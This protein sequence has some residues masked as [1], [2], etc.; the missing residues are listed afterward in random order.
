MGLFKYTGVF[1]L[2]LAIGAM[3]AGGATLFFTPMSGKKMRR[4]VVHLGEDLQDQA[5]DRAE[6]VQGQVQKMLRERN[7]QM[8]HNVR[9]PQNNAR[10]AARDWQDKGQK[11]A[12]EQG[13]G[14]F[15]AGRR[16][17]DLM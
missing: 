7:K 4:R 5:L 15:S 14:L 13:R 11:V 9:E 10:V 8:N 2:G 3:A 1:L 16:I 6:E 12:K 17:F